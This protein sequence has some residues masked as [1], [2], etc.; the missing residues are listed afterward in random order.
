MGP[1]EGY[2]SKESVGP[3]EPIALCVRSTVGPFRVRLLRRGLSDSAVA[4]VGIFPD[5]PIDVPDDAPENGCGWP[6][7]TDLAVPAGSPSGLYVVALSSLD[8]AVTAE[9]PFVVTPDAPGVR[10]R[11]LFAI[12]SSTYEAYNWWG[13]RS[14]Y[15]HGEPDG[16]QWFERAAVRVSPLRP[17]LGPDE[18][19][20]PKLQYWELPF[21][22]WLE[23]NGVVVDY[24]TSNELHADPE[25]LS[26]YGLLVSVGHDEY[27][28]WEMRDNVEQFA[29]DGGTVVVLSGNSVW[30]Q[31]RFEDDRGITCYKDRAR[32]PANADPATRSRV[33]VNW[34]DPELGRPETLMTG[35]SFQYGAMFFGDGV[36]SAPEFEVVTEHPVLQDTNLGVGN[37][38]GR[39]ADN[40]GR[41]PPWKDGWLTVLGYETDARPIPGAVADPPQEGDPS[42]PDWRS[43][44]DSI[45]TPVD[46]SVG[47]RP[48][49]LFYD[50][51][52]GE[53]ELH[54]IDHAG[55]L[56]LRKFHEGWR[57]SW[58]KI[59]AAE[60]GDS[61]FGGLLF[62]E[63]AAGLGEFYALGPHG[64][65]SLLQSQ[66]FW[67][68]SWDQIV[69]GR[70]GGSGHSDLLLYDRAAGVGEFYAT[71]GAANLAL[72]ASHDGWRPSWDL[73]VPG[74]FGGDGGTDLLFYDRSAGI[75]EFYAVAGG[76]IEFL[77]TESGWRSSWDVILPLRLG[78]DFTALMF[79]DRAG[80]TGEIYATDGSGNTSLL[81]THL[82]WR[83]TWKTIVPVQVDDH[84]TCLLFYEADTGYAELYAVDAGGALSFIRSYGD[85]PFTLVARAVF[86]QPDADGNQVTREYASMGVL[87]IGAGQVFG[88]STTDWSF[89]L[90]QSPSRWS[91]ID[92]ITANLLHLYGSGPRIVH[93]MTS[94]PTVDPGPVSAELERQWSSLRS[95]R[96]GIERAIPER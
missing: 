42:D 94:P 80:G 36:A 83:A 62:Y 53:A 55:S 73:I 57:G 75:G 88:A 12:P 17:Y 19:V 29:A 39:Y 33:T 71:D 66:Y 35:V 93:P 4:N 22:R 49:V 37:T 21:I 14:L 89:G 40:V 43:N 16:F 5:E 87:G 48:D 13:G 18:F 28:S 79:Y 47:S 70:F 92:Q 8:G 91:A 68:P 50:R 60:F 20:T 76:E 46:P 24:C 69:P 84:G 27:W 41:R 34:I 30:W 59:V 7:A 31:I 44:W 74:N 38:F 52:L 25:L 61:G 65:I 82:D 90:S 58:D 63:A 85:R 67:R 95:R 54:R 3:A 10:T 1:L 64:D 77:Q 6:A 2:V 78:L 15:G 26:G 96:D 23:R 72:L 9:I 11:I 86:P 45:V 56:A 32:D 51:A 81:Q